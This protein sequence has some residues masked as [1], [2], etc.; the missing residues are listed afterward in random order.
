MNNKMAMAIGIGITG[1]VTAWLANLRRRKEIE[2]SKRLEKE[3][4]D[5]AKNL[6]KEAF[7][8]PAFDVNLKS[9]DFEDELKES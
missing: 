6:V 9:V 2:E 7:P 8:C 3:M 1:A 4:D 5:F